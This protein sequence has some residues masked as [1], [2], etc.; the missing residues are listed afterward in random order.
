MSLLAVVTVA[1]ELVVRLLAALLGEKIIFSPRRLAWGRDGGI[2][3]LVRASCAGA[4]LC[5]LAATCSSSCLNL[6]R[7]RPGVAGP[8]P[9]SGS[10]GLWLGLSADTGSSPPSDSC[11][12]GV[13]V[14]GT[15]REQCNA[16]SLERGDGWPNTDLEAHAQ[17]EAYPPGGVCICLDHLLLRLIVIVVI[18]SI[19]VVVVVDAEVTVGL[20][21]C[22]LCLVLVEVQL[23]ANRHSEQKE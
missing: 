8:L 11:E 23:I 21:L 9:A 13:K 2:K 3:G 15:D 17:R 19:V 20:C 6:C 14:G 10:G 1:L 16:S 18:V 4:G 22:W 5:V 7:R 12:V